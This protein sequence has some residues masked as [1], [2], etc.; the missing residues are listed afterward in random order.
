METVIKYGKKG[1]ETAIPIHL[2]AEYTEMGTLDLRCRSLESDHRWKLSFQLRSS[3][4]ASQVSESQILDQDVVHR[5]CDVIR[6]AFITENR[7]KLQI[8]AALTAMTRTIEEIA[9][10]GRNDW[11]LS[12]IRSLADVLLDLMDRCAASPDMESRWLNMTGFCLRPG[13]GHG[14]DGERVKKLWKI[15]KKGPVF[16]NN[17]Q[18]KKEWWILWR[19]VAAGLTPGQQRQF[20]QDQ[21]SVL[22]P[23]N[24]K[25]ASKTSPQERIEIWMAMANM[26]RLPV[27]DKIRMGRK[28]LTE[29]QPGKTLPQHVWSL[30][31]FGVRDPLYGSVD[32][33]VPPAEAAAW[34][35]RLVG[36]PWKDP[37]H[38]S[39]ALV[40]M[41][42]KTGDRVR[43]VEPSVKESVL[44]FMK[45]HGI[46]IKTAAPLENV[47]ERSRGDE[48]AAFGESLP[49]GIML[50]E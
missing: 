42:R 27:N 17:A 30:S 39:A 15:Y 16:A 37:A 28:L 20:F 18:V 2:Q 44:G 9:G 49:A 13:L 35:G 46:S 38:V 43:D 26:E 7:S 25:S 3:E 32:R 23:K 1:V 22:D 40:R 8:N 33:V 19:R 21:A 29:I 36:M 12:L 14:Y 6:D 31:R 45:R 10:G 47:V 4:E 5:A 11:P 34:I 24:P 41:A 48:S 50:H